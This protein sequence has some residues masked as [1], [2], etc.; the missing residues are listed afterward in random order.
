M[1]PYEIPLS[2]E[3]QTLSISLA[4]KTYF[5]SLAFN[6]AGSYWVLDMADEDRVPLL[7]GVPLVTGLDL[8]EQ[9]SYLGI[10]GSLIVQTDFDADAVPTF[11]NLGVTGR[12]YFVVEE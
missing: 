4:G 3:P 12:L 8:L 1:T 5:L 7:T 6:R 10:G 2:P 11:E 9:Y